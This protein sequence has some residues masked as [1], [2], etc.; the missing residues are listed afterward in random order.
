LA[1]RDIWC[2]NKGELKQQTTMMEVQAVC[3][4]AA[5]VAQSVLGWE[6]KVA[7]SFRH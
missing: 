3:A 5:S 7:S 6:Q 2:V 4:F 1:L